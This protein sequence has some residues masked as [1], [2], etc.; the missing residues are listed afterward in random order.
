MQDAMS[1]RAQA[2][3][4]LCLQFGTALQEALADEQLPLGF[5]LLLFEQNDEGV[6]KELSYVTTV[7]RDSLQNLLLEFL[8]KLKQKSASD[9]ARVRM[10]L[11]PLDERE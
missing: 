4:T 3:Q 11:N 9:V 10:T 5:A 7:T 2:V 1:E 6:D 8:D